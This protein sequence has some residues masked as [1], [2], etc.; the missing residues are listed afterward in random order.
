MFLCYEKPA[1]ANSFIEMHHGTKY[2]YFLVILLHSA[3][4]FFLWIHI[5][6]ATSAL[7]MT[8]LFRFII[9]RPISCCVCYLGH[10][11]HRYSSFLCHAAGN[12]SFTILCPPLI[13]IFILLASLCYT[14]ARGKEQFGLCAANWKTNV[15][16]VFT[17]WF[18]RVFWVLVF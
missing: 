17:S 9:M 6:S 5:V 18:L 10:Q 16:L 13:L 12:P 15:N 2:F 7:H 1:Y 11:S 14:L 8:Y 4:T 3:L